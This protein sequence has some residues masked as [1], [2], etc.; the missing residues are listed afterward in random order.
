M[1]ILIPRQLTRDQY[2]KLFSNPVSGI[3]C[4]IERK[5]NYVYAHGARFYLKDIRYSK[6]MMVRALDFW[7]DQLHTYSMK[8]WKISH[9]L[10]SVIGYI[11]NELH[12]IGKFLGMV[13]ELPDSF[14]F[15][16]RHIQDIS[17]GDKYSKSM[18]MQ[19]MLLNT[20][21]SSMQ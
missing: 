18:S 5:T 10:V 12:E 20:K 14:L 2:I 9:P 6:S 1:G 11:M 19:L 16:H 13:K 3:A 17:K 4:E 21:A 15:S 7:F 8:V